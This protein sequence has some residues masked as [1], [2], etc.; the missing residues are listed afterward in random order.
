[1]GIKADDGRSDIADPPD[2]RLDPRQRSHPAHLQHMI[3]PIS[4]QVPVASYRHPSSNWSG[5]ACQ[6][7]FGSGYTPCS[8]RIPHL[9]LF[10]SLRVAIL[11]IAAVS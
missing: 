4:Q 5:A 9:M 11:R 2:P 3:V 1:M 8:R 6:Q 10:V 7:H